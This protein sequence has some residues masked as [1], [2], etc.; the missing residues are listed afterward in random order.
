MR[1]KRPDWP[2][3]EYIQQMMAWMLFEEQPQQIVQLGLGTGALTKFCYS[4]FPQSHVTTIELNPKVINVCH[5]MFKLP[6]N[7]ERL[8]VVPMDAMEFVCDHAH[9]GNADILQVD[10]YDAD[11]LGPVLDSPEFYAACADCLKPDG[12]MMINL[13]GDHPSYEKNLAA[14]RQTFTQ[15]LYLPEINAG[16]VVAFAFKTKRELDFQ[17]LYD[18]AIAIND[19]TGLPTR[20]WVSGLESNYSS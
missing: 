7:D 17:H 19:A 4:H 8:T 20:K 15:V 12:I 16:N 2:E 14:I 9:H 6:Q 1:I 5:A 18:R 11:A 13:F 10:L 3:L